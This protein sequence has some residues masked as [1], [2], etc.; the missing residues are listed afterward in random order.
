MS[1]IT[2]KTSWNSFKIYLDDILHIS[3]PTEEY[4][5][6]QSWKDKYGKYCIEIYTTYSK[7]RVDYDKPELWKE[8]LKVLDSNL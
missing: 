7:T 2:S 5:G 8:V 6:L 4:R 3:I 1:I